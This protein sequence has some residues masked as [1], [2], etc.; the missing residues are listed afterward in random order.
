MSSKLSGIMTAAAFCENVLQTVHVSARAAEETAKAAFGPRSDAT[1]ML[2]ALAQFSLAVIG[3][4][5]EEA[6]RQFPRLLA[7]REKVMS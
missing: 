6:A 4:D 7:A 1:L 2:G 5:E 3:G